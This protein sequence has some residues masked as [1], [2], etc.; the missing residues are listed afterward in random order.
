MRRA[1][2]RLAVVGLADAVVS[3]ATATTVHP[4]AAAPMPSL[5]TC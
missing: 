4:A 1:W 3:S 2:P 5:P